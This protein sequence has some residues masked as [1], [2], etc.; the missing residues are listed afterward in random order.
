MKT[1]VLS[2]IALIYLLLYLFVG[3]SNKSL[4]VNIIIGI[5]III[6]IINSFIVMNNNKPKV[7]FGDRKSVV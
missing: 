2:I 5:I 6:L 3:L 7:C 1:L 4:V